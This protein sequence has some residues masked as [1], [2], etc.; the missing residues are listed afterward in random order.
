MIFTI[1]YVI[2]S[3]LL[4]LIVYIHIKDIQ[5]LKEKVYKLEKENRQ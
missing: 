3:C 4:V 1:L 2:F 5:E